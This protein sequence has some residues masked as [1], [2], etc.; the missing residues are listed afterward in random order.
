MANAHDLRGQQFGDLTVIER[1]ELPGRHVQ[2]SCRCACG[3]TKIVRADNLK[4]GASRSCGLCEAAH[5]TGADPKAIRYAIQVWSGPTLNGKPYSFGEVHHVE[6]GEMVFRTTPPVHREGMKGDIHACV[7]RCMRALASDG[8][9]EPLSM[10][11][12]KRWMI[13]ERVSYDIRTCSSEDDTREKWYEV[14]GEP[15]PVTGTPSPQHDQHFVETPPLSAAAR[16]GMDA[17]LA[18]WADDGGA[19]VAGS[20][21]H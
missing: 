5:R 10:R 19:A 12:H 16:E 8:R 7:T 9:I 2:W 21:P 18:E 6:T 14:T 13:E 20:T 4:S 3:R 17:L 15:R 1:A 11:T